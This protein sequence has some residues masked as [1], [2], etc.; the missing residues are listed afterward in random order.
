MGFN[1]FRNTEGPS[2]LDVGLVVGFI[3]VTLALVAWG[4]FG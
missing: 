4:F 2:P 1:P 3:L